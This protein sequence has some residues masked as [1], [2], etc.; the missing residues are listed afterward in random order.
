MRE[1]EEHR[2][3]RFKHAIAVVRALTRTMIPSFCLL[4]V[5]P[6]VHG[7]EPDLRFAKTFQIPGC[8]EMIVVAEGDFE[9]RSIGSY[10]VRV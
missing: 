9:P 10:A 5:A 4:M 7:A 1:V 6:L 3:Q 8:A 2:L